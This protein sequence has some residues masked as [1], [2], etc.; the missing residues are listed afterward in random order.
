MKFFN[1]S[2][3]GKIR[4]NLFL[5]LIPLLLT[6][7][8][9]CSSGE[10]VIDISKSGHKNS[11]YYSDGPSKFSFNDSGDRFKVKIRDGRIYK[12]YKN[13]ERVDDDE[14][15]KYENL[16]FEKREELNNS[17]SKLKN[18]FNLDMD[19]L[20][21]NLA[22]LNLENNNELREAMKELKRELKEIDYDKFRTDIDLD[23][24]HD[25]LAELK[26][27]KIDIDMNDFNSNMQELS[28]NLSNIKVELNEQ[29]WSDFREEMTNLKDELKNLDLDMGDLKFEMKKIKRFMKDLREEL[30]DDG[31]LEYGE[32]DFDMEFNKNEL[33]IN[34]E[35]IPDSK[36]EKYKNMYEEHFGKEM[37]DGFRI[38]N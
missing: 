18:E 21:E 32:D 17:L 6:S 23:K 11:E 35:K 31:Y 10:D 2:N 4:L 25:D 1:K 8:T 22:S 33:I 15:S 26:N 38:R 29:N 34:G 30:V 7:L 36:F 20:R 24:L 5:M 12:L 37:E 16:V 14:I 19:E 9:A 13:G 27:I 28:E 3:L